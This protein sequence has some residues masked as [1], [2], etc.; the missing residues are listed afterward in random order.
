MKKTLIAALLALAS[1]AH[2]SDIMYMTNQEDGLIVLTD[3]TEGC[4]RGRAY[5]TTDQN[6][7]VGDT[8]CYVYDDP[9]IKAVDTDGNRFAWPV[10]NFTMTDYFIKKL[11]R[12]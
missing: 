12:K 6:A 8:G 5:Y 2:A 10:N 9:W 4:D 3:S 7:H 11:Q 1:Q